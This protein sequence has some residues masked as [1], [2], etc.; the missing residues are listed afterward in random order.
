MRKFVNFLGNLYC[1]LFQLESPR[2]SIFTVTDVQKKQEWLAGG[3]GGGRDISGTTAI[4]GLRLN[5]MAIIA[6]IAVIVLAL[7]FHW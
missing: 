5:S 7:I 4:W 2:Q 3:R 1:G 6:I